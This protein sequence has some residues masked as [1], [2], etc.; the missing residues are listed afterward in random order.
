MVT[1]VAV[2]A[3]CGIV[4]VSISTRWCSDCVRGCC[5]EKVQFGLNHEMVALLSGWA[6]SSI[7]KVVKVW[8]RRKVTPI[9]SHLR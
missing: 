3:I 5:F 7:A 9:V 4:I 2:L 6:V 8:P 1:I